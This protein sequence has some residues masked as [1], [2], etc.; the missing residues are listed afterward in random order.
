MCRRHRAGARFAWVMGM[1]FIDPSSGAGAKTWALVLLAVA[2]CLIGFA[3]VWAHDSSLGSSANT[4]SAAGLDEP[5][6][7]LREGAMAEDLDSEGVVVLD[8]LLVAGKDSDDPTPGSER[9]SSP[10]RGDAGSSYAPGGPCPDRSC[11]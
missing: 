4:A 9:V 7:A 5:A 3:A 11:E 8:L 10:E 1:A 2:L 6:P